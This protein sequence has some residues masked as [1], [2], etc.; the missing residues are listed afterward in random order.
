MPAQAY[1]DAVFLERRGAVATNRAVPVVY[2]LPGLVPHL[3][4]RKV[5]APVRVPEPLTANGPPSL[6]LVHVQEP[7]RVAVELHIEVLARG[8]L[9]PRLG[10]L[11]RASVP[12]VSAK[13]QSGARGSEKAWPDATQCT[14]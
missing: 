9:G 4:A 11:A 7:F 12:V 8:R 5:R 3:V 1:G 2:K 6:V 14:L 13:A 10:R